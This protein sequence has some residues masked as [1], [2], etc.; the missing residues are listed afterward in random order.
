MKLALGT[1]I[2]T[3]RYKDAGWHTLDA[4]PSRE[5][6]FINVVPPLPEE[7]TRHDWQCVEAVHFIEHLY[8][9][10]V[11]QLLREIYQVLEPNGCLIMEQ[12]DIARVMRVIV[13]LDHK[14]HNFYMYEYAIF[15]DQSSEDPYMCH[16]YGW[17]PVTLS[18]ECYDVGFSAVK[19]SE[20]IYHVPE[21][22]FRLVAIK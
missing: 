20:A 11:R 5:A 13:G 10:E 12:P 18:K 16:R 2:E 8:I 15:G 7:V 9:W 6:K 3:Q 14:P 22:D 19:L 21:R 1:G 4:N 17:T